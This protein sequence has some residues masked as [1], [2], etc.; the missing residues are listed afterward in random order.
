MPLAV[1]LEPLRKMRPTACGAQIFVYHAAYMT[2]T[3]SL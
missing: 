3:T 1:A 2:C